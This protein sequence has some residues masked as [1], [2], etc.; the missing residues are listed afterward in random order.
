MRSVFNGMK[1][2][3]VVGCLVSAGD[4]SGDG[5]C[6]AMPSSCC[7]PPLPWASRP[8]PNWRGNETRAC[9]T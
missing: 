9:L 8:A 3:L 7:V 1:A 6:S 2:L 4:L 5:S